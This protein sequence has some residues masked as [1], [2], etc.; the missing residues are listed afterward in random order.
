MN[1]LLI[2]LCLGMMSLP[3]PSLYAH[4][5]E[6]VVLSYDQDT[7]ALTA[8]VVHPVADPGRH[9]VD[10]IE[11]LLNGKRVIEK[12]PPRQTETGVS[13]VFPLTDVKPGDI[14]K[15]TAFCNRGGEQSEQIKIA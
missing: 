12:E 14:V 9:F 6:K 3:A 1:K 8:E 5:P 7:R 2:V 4:A 15:V 11:V 13:E 10:R